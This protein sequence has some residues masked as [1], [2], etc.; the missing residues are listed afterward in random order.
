MS[1][2][3]PHDVTRN[4]PRPFSAGTDSG[5]RGRRAGREV[6]GGRDEVK[7]RCESDREQGGE[8][9]RDRARTDKLGC[10]WIGRA[11]NRGYKWAKHRSVRMPRS[12]L[13]VA[14]PPINMSAGNT[15]AWHT[16]SRRAEPRRAAPRRGMATPKSHGISRRVRRTAPPNSSFAASSSPRFSSLSL[17][18]SLLLFLALSAHFFPPLFL[19]PSFFLPPFLTPRPSRPFLS[20]PLFPPSPPSFSPYRRISFLR[21]GRTFCLFHS[22]ARHSAPRFYTFEYY[23]NVDALAVDAESHCRCLRPVVPREAAGRKERRE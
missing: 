22:P 1:S 23:G 13:Q 11:A 14:R 12:R 21:R 3:R 15:T 18:L 5:R 9:K 16:A 7:E 20:L 2:L 6:E 19:S 4:H 17:P 10:R 8:G